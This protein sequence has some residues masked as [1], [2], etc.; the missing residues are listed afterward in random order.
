MA[1]F[2]RKLPFDLLNIGRPE[3]PL[4]GKADITLLFPRRSK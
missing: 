1:A 4:S 2:G 3:R